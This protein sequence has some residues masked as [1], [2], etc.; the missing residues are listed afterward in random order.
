MRQ[1]R[2]HVWMTCLGAHHAA[3]RRSGRA[4]IAKGHRSR[5]PAAAGNL[6][7]Y[8]RASAQ[9]YE[10]ISAPRAISTIFGAFQLMCQFPIAATTAVQSGWSIPPSC[11]TGQCVT[12]SQDA[13]HDLSRAGRPSRCELPPAH[14]VQPGLVAGVITGIRRRR[15]IDR[16]RRVISRR[17]VR[18]RRIGTSNRGPHAE[19]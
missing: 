16:R 9:A 7:N 10:L 19:T 8:V 14:D 6:A 5:Q 12:Q 3:P 2:F 17:V 4:G 15:I 18:R 13:W 11:N 1:G